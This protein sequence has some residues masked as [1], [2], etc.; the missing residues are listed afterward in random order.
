MAIG[1]TSADPGKFFHKGAPADSALQDF[2]RDYPTNPTASRGVVPEALKISILPRL[3][4]APRAATQSCHPAPLATAQSGG[5]C[6]NNSPSFRRRGA[7]RQFVEMRRQARVA[8]SHRIFFNHLA[9]VRAFPPYRNP[10]PSPNCRQTKAR[11]ICFLT[12]PKPWSENSAP[13]QG[14][15]ALGSVGLNNQIAGG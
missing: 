14:F 13:T 11:F 6:G 9:T 3:R 8:L 15:Q 1:A 4:C 10:L 12:S 5:A 7:K 2:A